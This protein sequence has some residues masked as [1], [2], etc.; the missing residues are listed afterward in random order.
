MSFNKE[1][2][3]YEGYIYKIVNDVND[4]IYIGQTRRTVEERWNYHI[5]CQTAHCGRC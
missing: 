1:T 3:L 2:G 4:K 5:Y